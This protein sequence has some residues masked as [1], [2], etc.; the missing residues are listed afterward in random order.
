MIFFY[1]ATRIWTLFGQVPLCPYLGPSGRDFATTFF[2]AR[3][4]KN[5]KKPGKGDD[6]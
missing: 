6:D 2:E 5:Y 1:M 4:L 3:E